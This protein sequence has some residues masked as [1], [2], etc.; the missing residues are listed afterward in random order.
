MTETI[1]LK[2][3]PINRLELAISIEHLRT[4]L[5]ALH[6]AA[7]A[8]RRHAAVMEGN[9]TLQFALRNWRAMNLLVKQAAQQ[10][11]SAAEAAVT[12]AEHLTN[13][14]PNKKADHEAW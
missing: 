5:Q 3:V 9:E 6:A 2:I 13:P 1:G 8:S 4:T 10:V 7:D 11:E 12:M 14:N